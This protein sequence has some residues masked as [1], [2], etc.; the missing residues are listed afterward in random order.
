MRILLWYVLT[1]F[2]HS[3]ALSA[4]AFVIIFIVVDLSNSISAYLDR[5][6]GAAQILVYYAWSVPYFL[7][8]ILPMAMLLGSL[9]CIGGLARR[10]ELSAMKSSGVS[11]YRILAPIQIFALLVSLGAW[12]SSTKLI[13]MANRERAARTVERI[14]PARQ[15]RTQLVLRDVEGQV[16]TIGEYR[17]DRKSGRR[18]TIDRYTDG[19]L[20]SKTRADELVWGETGWELLNGE[21]RVF[22]ASGERV[23][24]FDSSGAE[25]LTLTPEDLGR[26]TRPIDQL[27][28][29]D[30]RVLVD[31]KRMNGLEA[32]R[33]RVELEL[34]IALSVSGLAMVMFGLPLS[35]HT[36]RAS[37]PLQIG[38]CLL[39]SFLFYGS[40]QAMRAMGWNGIGSPVTAAW[41]PNV[42]F[43]VVGLAMWRRAHT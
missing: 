43:M 6:V 40:L 1:R 19:I 14:I 9:F 41:L 35:S 8:L 22:G 31:R 26:K 36:R 11:L 5:G 20:L 16:V 29:S 12:W 28:T 23:T 27:D 24:A 37:R 32:V 39:L 4:V 18:V 33:D 34:R 17:V 25:T 15:H 7:F 13:P 21:H 30:L 38:I 3:F 10:N 2:A 42:L